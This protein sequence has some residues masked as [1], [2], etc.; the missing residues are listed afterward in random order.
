[1]AL[2]PT[3]VGPNLAPKEL[4][5]GEDCPAL[6]SD[7]ELG[8]P[9]MWDKSLSFTLPE[10]LV[11]MEDL[12]ED[13]VSNSDESAETAIMRNKISDIIDNTKELLNLLFGNLG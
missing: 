11:D 13:S 10:S 9:A 5:K 8:L 3:W 7:Q 2:I 4:S 1:M 12:R 6:I